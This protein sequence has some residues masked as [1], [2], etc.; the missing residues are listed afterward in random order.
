MGK[1]GGRELNYVSDVDVVFVG[2]GNRRL[3]GRDRAG[4]G[5]WRQPAAA[6]FANERFERWPIQRLDRSADAGRVLRERR[7]IAGVAFERVPGQ[8]A[9]CHGPACPTNSRDAFSSY[10]PRVL[11]SLVSGY[12]LSGGVLRTID[13]PGAANPAVPAITGLRSAAVST[14]LTWLAGVRAW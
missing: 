13:Q 8:P 11:T 5:T 3:V 9:G 12:F 1:A 6:L 2:E 7:E 10:D 4:D 14:D